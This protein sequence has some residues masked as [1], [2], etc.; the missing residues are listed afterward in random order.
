MRERVAIVTGAGQGIGNAIA[1]RFLE[2]GMRVTIAESDEEAGYEAAERL[3][4][5]GDVLYVPTD[6]AKESQVQEMVA[7][8]LQVWGRLDFLVNNAGI[9]QSHGPAVTDLSLET[10]NRVLAVNL[11]GS[12]LCA[13]HSSPHLKARQG[14]AIVNIASTRALMSESHTEALPH[15]KAV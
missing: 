5:V 15:L 13:K 4:H 8:T 12:F 9:A 11:T 14:G 3:K 10:W 2:E 1:L 7:K 6:V